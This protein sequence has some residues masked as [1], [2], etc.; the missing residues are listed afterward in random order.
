MNTFNPS[1]LLENGPIEYLILEN[2]EA[3]D[4]LSKALQEFNDEIDKITFSQRLQETTILESHLSNHSKMQQLN[5]LNEAIA[6]NIKNAWRN[7][8]DKV[9]KIFSKVSESV[10]SL[11]TTKRYL[12]KYKKIILGQN[13][14]SATYESRDIIGAITKILNY[15]IPALNYESMG[16]SLD[17]PMEY[18][19]KYI[20]PSIVKMNGGQVDTSVGGVSDPTNVEQ[21]GTYCNDFFLGPRKEISTAVI[22]QYIKDIYDYMYDYRKI[23]TKINKDIKQI[24]KDCG[25]ITKKMGII[26]VDKDISNG[27]PNPDGDTNKGDQAQI[28]KQNGAAVGESFMRPYYSVLYEMVL[29]EDVLNE[30]TKKASSTT[31]VNKP[32]EGQ[33]DKTGTVANNMKNV[34][35][36]DQDAKNRNMDA[37]GN[38][39]DTAAGVKRIKSYAE[40]STMVLRAKLTAVQFTHTEFDVVLRDHVKS[41]ISSNTTSR[42]DKAEN[43]KI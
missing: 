22:Q 1:L 23:S 29:T 7:F 16:T 6:A 43:K 26:T 18:F 37:T 11:G 12:D 8:V 27:G 5:I 42:E 24:E 40:V 10:A 33:V 39:Q 32:D 2:Y 35:D 25:E 28:A 38:E 34:Q 36:Q 14:V 9:K 20:Q 4:E 13:F 15:E 17:D 19:K 3:P 41:Y 30:I 31:T 21:I